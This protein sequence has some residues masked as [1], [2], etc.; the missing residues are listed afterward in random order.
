MGLLQKGVAAVIEVDECTIY[1][2]E[3]NRVTPAVRLVPRIIMFLGYCPHTPILPFPERLKL[4]RQSS[5][6]SRKKVAQLLGVNACTLRRWEAARER[7][8]E[9]YMD[10]IKDL[11]TSLVKGG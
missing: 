3:T 10:I 1:N 9:K 4:I 5:G 2:W 11:P 7:L 8:A 6:L